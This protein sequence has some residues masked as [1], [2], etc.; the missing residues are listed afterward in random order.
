MIILEFLSF[1]IKGYIVDSIAK[2]GEVFDH[3]SSS[4][5]APT[6]L[7]TAEELRMKRLAFLEGKGSNPGGSCSAEES[8]LSSSAV[9]G[10]KLE[11]LSF[12]ILH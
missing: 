6:T 12:C 3:G 2:G 10:G 7:L 5:S 11:C 8:P 4:A 1:P 9:D